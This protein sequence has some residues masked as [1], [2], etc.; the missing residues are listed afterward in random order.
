MAKKIIAIYH[1][2][3]FLHYIWI[4]GCC[5]QDGA[6]FKKGGDQQLLD[7]DVDGRNAQNFHPPKMINGSHKR[8]NQI[9]S[10]KYQQ[11]KYREIGDFSSEGN[12]C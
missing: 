8:C 7:D 5:D 9:I 3:I 12:R 2:I 10:H 1:P 11:A 6:I 4:C